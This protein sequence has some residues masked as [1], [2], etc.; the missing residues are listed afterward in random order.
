[1]LQEVDE[2]VALDPIADPNLLSAHRASYASTTSAHSN[3]ESYLS[4]IAHFQT[5]RTTNLPFRFS[6]ASESDG[7]GSIAHSPTPANGLRRILNRHSLECELGDLSRRSL[8]MSAP[9]HGTPSPRNSFE[10]NPSSPISEMGR[11][12]NSSIVSDLPSLSIAK[13]AAAH[14][15]NASQAFV[16][17][18]T[19]SSLFSL[20]SVNSSP[21]P[22]PP[23]RKLLMLTGNRLPRPPPAAP[24]F[25]NDKAGNQAIVIPQSRIRPSMSPQQG[26]VQR[27][28]DTWEAKLSPDKA[29][30]RSFESTSSPRYVRPL[31]NGL[32]TR[33]EIPRPRPLSSLSLTGAISKADFSNRLCRV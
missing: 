13:N 11:M 18:S 16:K 20:S 4:S 22:R 2:D 30:E 15:V 5:A 17:Q 31:P 28:K 32:E 14:M 10:T 29:Q 3:R 19:Q 23:R 6:S 8:D 24:V 1:M 25:A 33:A 27:L 9:G 21:C 7:T 26:R 12:A